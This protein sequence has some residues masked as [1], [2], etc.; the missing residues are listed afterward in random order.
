MDELQAAFLSVKLKYLDED[1]RRRVAVA[2]AYYEHVHGKEIVLPEPGGEGEHIWHQYVVRCSERD[3][4]KNYLESEGV[5]TL[6][7]YPIHPHKLQW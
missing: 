4:L 7:H 1:N 3:R 5:G 2:K 6:I